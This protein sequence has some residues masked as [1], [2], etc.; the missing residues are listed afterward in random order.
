MASGQYYLFLTTLTHQDSSQLGIIERFIDDSK[1]NGVKNRKDNE[2]R[3]AIYTFFTCITDLNKVMVTFRDLF[4]VRKSKNF[5]DSKIFTAKTF[6]IN[7][8]NRSIN[9]FAT[10][11]RKT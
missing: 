10:N 1:T 2:N 4:R 3:F 8:V 7:C 6:R 5:P 9:D 11:A